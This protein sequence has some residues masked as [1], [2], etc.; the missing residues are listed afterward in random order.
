MLLR[1][2]IEI[3]EQDE[4]EEDDEAKGGQNIYIYHYFNNIRIIK[5]S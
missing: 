4:E 2:S 3:I 5:I 1:R